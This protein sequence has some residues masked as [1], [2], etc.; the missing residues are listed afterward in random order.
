M[1]KAKAEAARDCCCGQPI[2]YVTGTPGA[3]VET[4]EIAPDVRAELNGAGEIVSIVFPY[5]LEHSE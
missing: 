3:V 5:G 2:R 1:T 4:R